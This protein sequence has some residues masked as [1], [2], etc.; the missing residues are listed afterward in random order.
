MMPLLLKAFIAPSAAT[1]RSFI[2][3]QKLGLEVSDARAA[4]SGPLSSERITICRT[5]PMINAR[6]LEGA[7]SAAKCPLSL[8]Y[9]GSMPNC[10]ASSSMNELS[11]SSLKFSS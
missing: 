7:P 3:V 8:M 2:P 9:L 4:A 5:R 1:I 11:T 10:A 6:W